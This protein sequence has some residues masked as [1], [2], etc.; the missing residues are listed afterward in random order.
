M[1]SD[2]QPCGI[3]TFTTDFGGRDPF[4]AL[5]KAAALRRLPQARLVDI[6][7]ELPAFR[8]EVAGFWLQRSFEWFPEGSVHVAVVD[9]GVG[10]ARR[11]LGVLVRGHVLIAP[12]NGLLGG[13]LERWPEAVVSAL[14]ATLPAALGLPT[15]SATFHGRDVMAPVAAEVAAGRLDPRALGPQVSDWVRGGLP[16][17]QRLA[18]EVRG[19]VVT[20]D[21][22]GNLITNIGAELVSAD[23]APLEV[24]AAGQD[25]PWGR[26][27]ADVPEGRCLGLVNSF[28]VVEIGCNRGSAARTL[29]LNETD[30]VTV[31]GGNPGTPALIKGLKGGAN[32]L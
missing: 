14:E 21:R 9:P 22:Y 19:R 27:Y 26:T 20:I 12:D 7:H 13:I 4:V 3:I 28:G 29:S 10:S 8:P 23:F 11:L 1:S 16:V 30:P 6:T 2:F 25:L 31:L 17:A 15:P 18:R 5:L 24:Q 32:P